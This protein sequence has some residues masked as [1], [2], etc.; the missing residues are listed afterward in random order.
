MSTTLESADDFMLLA[1]AKRPF[2]TANHAAH[3]QCA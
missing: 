1:V 2:P 3:E